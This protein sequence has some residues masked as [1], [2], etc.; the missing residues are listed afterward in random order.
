MPIHTA[1]PIRVFDQ[2]SFHHIDKRVTGLAFDIHNEFGRYLDERLYQ[3]ELTRRCHML[4]FEVEPELQIDATLGDF[5]KSYFADHLING[6][7]IVETKVVSALSAAHKAQV[8]NYLFL[9]GLHHA[10]LLNFRPERVQHEFVSTSLTHEDRRQYVI[11]A[12]R[13]KPLTAGC[14]KL[15]DCLH[16]LLA[17]WGAYLDPILYRDGLTHFLGGDERVIRQIGVISGG[18]VVCTQKVHTVTEDIA[19]SVTASIHRP[20][21]VFEHQRRFLR[22]TSLRA[23]QWVNLNHKRIELCTIERP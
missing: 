21:L 10:T 1:I 23:L 12:S 2:E 22:H 11:V 6:G 7:V 9:C 20:E 5:S 16:H 19:F 17:E 14:R 13:W 18:A 8:L 15:H 4:G 3:A